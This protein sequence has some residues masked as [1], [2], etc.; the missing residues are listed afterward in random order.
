MQWK[1]SADEPARYLPPAAFGRS[2]D[3]WLRAGLR[4]PGLVSELGAFTSAPS[5]TPMPSRST[6]SP[7][8]HSVTNARPAPSCGQDQCRTRRPL[9]Q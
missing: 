9:W 6:N 8:S 5:C 4:V 3:V 1:C 7:P 2:A